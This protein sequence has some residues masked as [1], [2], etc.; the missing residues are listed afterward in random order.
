MTMAKSPNASAPIYPLLLAGLTLLFA[1]RVLGQ[2]AVVL[3]QPA[4]LPPFE[5]WYSGLMPYP[6]LLPTQVIMIVVMIKVVADVA[7]GAGFFAAL[8]PRIGRFLIW[9]SYA[10]AAG[11]AIRY[12]L[13][14]SLHPELRWFTGTI[15]IWFHL[16]LAAFLY[17][18][19]RYQIRHRPVSV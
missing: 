15:P 11:M 7:R 18:L 17:T 8:G 2:L 13:T 6:L 19:G 9:G 14:M 12:V 16:V 10:Y 4:W 3:F 1:L 5:R